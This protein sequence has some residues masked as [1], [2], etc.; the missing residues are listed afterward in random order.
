[1]KRILISLLILQFVFSGP[2]AAQDTDSLLN[3]D[4]SLVNDYIIQLQ[5][6]N[7]NRLGATAFDLIISDIAIAGGSRE[8]IEA[9]RQSEGGSKLVVAYMS[10][11]Q[12]AR[13][14]YYWQP[15]W[16]R[17]DGTW[18]EWAVEF[19]ATWAND[20]WVQYWHP[21]WQEIILTGA[22]AYID[23]IIDQGFDGVLLD[24]VDAAW[25]FES[26]G[27][28]TAYQEMADFVIAIANHSR[29]RSPN[30]GIF[31]INGEDIGLR[32]REQGYMDTV[33][34]LLV[35]DLYY[36]YPTDNVASPADWTA[37]R[38]AMLDEWVTAGR[39]VL[40]VDYTRFDD[41]IN[42]AYT[43]S[44]ERGYIPYVSSRSLSRL[45]IHEGHEPD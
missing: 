9:L 39:L 14:Q 17:E 35:E 22:D 8:R 23:R 24:R 3:R 4:W 36:G 32:F 26:Q 13:F 16:R 18:P 43:R 29:E 27:R 2:L 40:T 19:D 34:G 31:T 28:E 5:R 15:E 6:G 25:Y 38:E 10:I 33:T 44:S 20:V 42:D 45:F 11:G 37:G 1:M 7:V 41:Q 30:F 12:A 21:G